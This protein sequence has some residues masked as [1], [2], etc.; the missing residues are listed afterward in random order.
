MG[1]GIPLAFLL[2]SPKPTNNSTA[3]PQI[4]RHPVCQICYWLVPGT[5]LAS[6]E[7]NSRL[8]RS[9][10]TSTVLLRLSSSTDRIDNGYSKKKYYT[11]IRQSDLEKGI[12]YSLLVFGHRRSC[13]KRWS[14]SSWIP[15]DVSVTVKTGKPACAPLVSTNSVLRLPLKIPCESSSASVLVYS[16]QWDMTWRKNLEIWD[17]TLHVT[18]STLSVIG[19]GA[20]YVCLTFKCISRHPRTRYSRTSGPSDTDTEI[21]H[22]V[23]ALLPH[24][25]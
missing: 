6:V 14:W 8:A 1:P 20:V 22:A 7:R 13:S 5:V 24:N 4:M 3:S 9:L 19:I 15:D 25:W 18:V 12:P 23:I 11:C 16:C 10:R 2:I 21:R 17:L